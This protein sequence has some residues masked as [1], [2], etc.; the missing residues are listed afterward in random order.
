MHRIWRP[1]S[2][3]YFLMAITVIALVWFVAHR[4]NSF[5]SRTISMR[6]GYLNEVGHITSGNLSQLARS[7]LLNSPNLNLA[8]EN[9]ATMDPRGYFDAGDRQA[10][11]L[12][13]TVTDA[14]GIVLYD[15]KGEDLNTN[16]S[17]R[18]EVSAALSNGYERRFAP[19]D[20]DT[21]NMFVALPI[22]LDDGIVGTVV[23][24]KSNAILKPLVNE[25]KRSMELVGLAA[26]F[27]V[28]LIIAT[29]FL[30][31]LRPIELWF[32]Y[33]ELFKRRKH[34]IKP[35]LRRTRF[36]L[37]GEALDHIFEALSNRRYIENMMSCM[38]HEM[39][40]P[41]GSI[42][43]SAELLRRDMTEEAFNTGIRNIHAETQRMDKTITKLL[44]LAALEK[45]NSLKE[46]HL[47]DVHHILDGIDLRFRESMADK[48]IAL[49]F[50]APAGLQIYCEPDLLM[51]ALGNLIQ[52]SIDHSE[53]GTRIDLHVL[54]HDK[55]VEFQVIDQG[56]GIP[57]HAKDRV[58][59]KFYSDKVRGKGI[60][61]GLPLVQEVADLHYG[62]ISIGNHDSG[63]AIAILTIMK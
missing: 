50:D 38:A 15:T 39:R 42:Q 59:D 21:F 13:L 23:V 61:L 48:G 30:I 35:N 4:V 57:N 28:V 58:F 40:N 63:G 5:E 12:H 33:T 27:I 11:A 10:L 1:I 60:G 52:N 6:E 24:S 47:I 62:S 36:G 22:R 49:S 20:R 26:A 37:F 32:S 31:F 19:I 55:K 34:P 18:P 51:Q 53:G 8:F 45:R 7:G 16:I 56:S 46:L 25:T 29:L 44:N 43:T 3:V 54:E 9:F 17:N 14:Q 41:V 2:A